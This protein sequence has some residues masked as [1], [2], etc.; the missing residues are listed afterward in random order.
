MEISE[1]NSLDKQR[2]IFGGF[3]GDLD[4]K[5][6]MKTNNTNRTPSIIKVYVEYE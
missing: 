1:L 3:N 2:L 5:I 4:F 6:A